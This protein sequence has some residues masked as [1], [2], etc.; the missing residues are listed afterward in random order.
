MIKRG[1][2][3][4]FIALAVTVSGFSDD[5]RIDGDAP[6][7]KPNNP[8][9]PIAKGFSESF[10]TELG[11][12]F[13]EMRDEIQGMINDMIPSGFSSDD[14]L[15]GFGTSSVFASHGAT[16]RAYADYKFL[17][18]SMG[19]MLGLKFP[20]GS[21]QV[22][23]NGLSSGGFDLDSIGD[24]TF[25]INPQFFSI[26]IGFNPSY[27][28]KIM[29]E[30]L[31]LGLRLGFFGLPTLPIQMSDDVSA[32]LN[33]NTFTIGLTANYQLVPSVNLGLIKWRGVNVG[34]GL[35]FQTTKLDLTVP[36]GEKRETTTLQQSGY[37]ATLDLV[38]DPTAALNIDINTVTIPVEIFTAINLL[39]LNI[40][41][42]LGV[43]IGFGKS[44]LSIGMQSDVK[45]E[46]NNSDAPIS[47]DKNGSLSVKLE[48]D[49]AP[50][51]F[52]L[53]L[54]TGLGFSFGDKFVIDIPIT[55]YL[56]D[57]YNLGFTIGL[58]F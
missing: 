50:T 1:I 35:I 30:N 12:A 46:S 32:D 22:L 9:D 16:M 11:K 29:P 53:K 42:G 15:N 34:S 25:G 19:S 10:N 55:F 4:A 38:L 44:A 52:N 18:I 24:T 49:H 36:F 6:T 27:L 43:D 37:S 39:F 5:I 40:P 26:H 23:L 14:L 33:F 51:A 56:Q 3:C 31:F 54:M 20:E 28:I 58:R 17:S 7:F 2:L 48:N 45:I 41:L 21:T 47:P 57:G 13:N 8:N